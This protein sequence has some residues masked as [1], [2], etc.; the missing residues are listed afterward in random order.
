MAACQLAAKGR[1]LDDP[2]YASELS[3]VKA[4]ITMQSKKPQQS[5][6]VCVVRLIRKYWVVVDFLL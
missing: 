2:S 3:G 6:V 1:S 4:F 5:D